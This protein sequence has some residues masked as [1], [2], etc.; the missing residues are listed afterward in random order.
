MP[1]NKIFGRIIFSICLLMATPNLLYAAPRDV[2][3]T[4][5]AEQRLEYLKKMLESRSGE[6]LAQHN[7]G[8]TKQQIN[9]LLDQAREAV[10]DGNEKKAASI[11]REAIKTF[12]SAVRALPEEPEKVARFKTRYEDMRRGLERF[13]NA[14]KTNKER[15]LQE[16]NDAKEYSQTE[17][18]NLLTQADVAAGEGHYEKAISHLKQAQSIVTA[19]LQGLLNNKQLV[20]EFDVSTP[21]KEYLYELRRY[22]GY[23]DLVPVAIDVK[24]PSNMTRNTML[25]LDSKAKKMFEAAS[26]KALNGDYPIAIRMMMDATNVIRQALK[27]VDAAI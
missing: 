9:Q 12:T 25:E 10:L 21:E 16:Q 26:S 19:S 3:D 13:T 15:F 27:L 17:V 5:S 2:S 23:E 24:K 11:T 22:H 7:N 14:Q 1:F 6:R 4:T 18:N 20:I 8:K